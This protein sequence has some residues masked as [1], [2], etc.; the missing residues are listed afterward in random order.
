MS[1]E[2]ETKVAEP[3]SV[4]SIDQAAT[5]LIPEAVS[6]DKQ[7]VTVREGPLLTAQDLGC[8]FFYSPTSRPD[9]VFEPLLCEEAEHLKMEGVPVEN[10]KEAL[11]LKL[12]AVSAHLGYP[13]AILLVADDPLAA[14]RLIE[15]S[16]GTVP[17]GWA[18]NFDKLTQAQLFVNGGLAYRDK[19]IVC[20][21]PEGL[22]KVSGELDLMLTRG[23]AVRQEILNKKYVTSLEEFRA[24]CFP[25]FIGIAS[26]K[27]GDILKHP[28]IIR[29]PVVQG[30]WGYN[31]TQD[32]PSS[33][34]GGKP[35]WVFRIRKCFKRLRPM[36]V[37]IP[38]QDHSGECFKQSH[39]LPGFP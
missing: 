22:T 18:I 33:A 25:S 32:A 27:R 30:S 35:G 23:Y 11:M 9:G 14:A 15:S 20:Q 5:I 10:L 26:R 36:P 4:P 39:A 29:I 16:T 6:S 38:F 21:D 19:C 13:L 31:H 1:Q 37:L 2:I 7:P 3:M 17:L 8:L 28:S 12:G 34:M 24:E